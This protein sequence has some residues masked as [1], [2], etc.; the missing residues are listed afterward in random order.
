MRKTLSVPRCKAPVYAGHHRLAVIPHRIRIVRSPVPPVANFYLSI[1]VRRLY[2]AVPAPRFLARVGAGIVVHG[3]PVIALLH[4]P[5]KIRRMHFAIPTVCRHATEA[6]AIRAIGA[7]VTGSGRFHDVPLGTRNEFR[8]RRAL[9]V[10]FGAGRIG[11]AKTYPAVRER[12][13]GTDGF[14][15]LERTIHLRRISIVETFRASAN[16]IRRA[17]R[18]RDLVVTPLRRF[19]RRIARCASRSFRIA[20]APIPAAPLVPDGIQACLCIFIPCAERLPQTISRAERDN[21]GIAFSIGTCPANTI[22]FLARHP[23]GPPRT[24]R[25]HHRAKIRRTYVGDRPHDQQRRHRKRGARNQSHGVPGK[26]GPHGRKIH[27]AKVYRNSPRS[28][29]DIFKFPTQTKPR[30][31]IRKKHLLGEE[32]RRFRL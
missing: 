11:A 1:R 31:K 8:V 25:H 23:V 6:L 22:S 21:T 5:R 29:V 15:C 28:A 14:R 17:C 2:D 4:L 24:T 27:S 18:R 26:E 3:I 19:G 32:V 13:S 20:T 16:K 30:G 7:P 12:T 10:A 9:I